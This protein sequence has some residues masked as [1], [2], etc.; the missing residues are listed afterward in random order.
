MGREETRDPRALES[1]VVVSGVGRVRSRPLRKGVWRVERWAE[2]RPHSDPRLEKRCASAVTHAHESQRSTTQSTRAL[3]RL[4]WVRVR[5]IAMDSRDWRRTCQWVETSRRSSVQLQLH[6]SAQLS[7]ILYHITHID[8]TSL[9]GTRPLT[10]TCRT[11]QLRASEGPRQ[12]ST[13]CAERSILNIHIATWCT[14]VGE[15]TET[16]VEE[17]TGGGL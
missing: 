5:S 16:K 3:T 11:V 17:V 2:T 13:R 7:W 1:L 8:I 9:R 14:V 6:L 4:M 10:I 12:A 15:E